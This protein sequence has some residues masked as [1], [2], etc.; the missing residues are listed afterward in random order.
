MYLADLI[1]SSRWLNFLREQMR[2]ILAFARTTGGQNIPRFLAL[3]K[4]QEK[5]KSQVGDP[6]HH[7][8]VPGGTVFHLNKIAETLKQDMANPHV[9]PHMKF[10][11]H[12][13]GT[14]MS[15]AWHGFKMVHKVGNSVLTTFLRVSNRIFYVN[16]LVRCKKDYFIPLRWIAYGQEK[17]LS[18]VGY[19]VTESSVC[20]NITLLVLAY[21]S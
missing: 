9:R 20:L 6:T 2:I 5:L 13:E 12:V 11:P 19:C 1:S 14:H 10:L 18:A 16:K 7:Y 4:T 3:Q 17:D 15:Q 21:Y 8:V